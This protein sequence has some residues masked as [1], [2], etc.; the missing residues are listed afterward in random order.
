MVLVETGVNIN[1]RRLTVPLALSLLGGS[2]VPPVTPDGLGT[3][4]ITSVM[5]IVTTRG[6]R[7]LMAIVTAQS[8]GTGIH[9]TLPACITAT[10]VLIARHAH[11]VLMASTAQSVKIVA[12]RVAPLVPNQVINV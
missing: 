3:T 5:H 4:V 10:N 8:G 12:V 6:A 9:V 2:S 7:C 11:A 1:V